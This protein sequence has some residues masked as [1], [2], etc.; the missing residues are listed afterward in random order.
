MTDMSTTTTPE[1]GKATAATI[2]LKADDATV[3]IRLADEGLLRQVF[4]E[5]FADVRFARV[6]APLER[7]TELHVSS[8]AL[9]KHELK[10][11]LRKLRAW[12]EAG[13]IP[14]GDRSRGASQ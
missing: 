4:G 6:A 5:H 8:H 13:E 11:G 1:A 12:I 9:G 7:G 14:T 3:G 2:T 10:A